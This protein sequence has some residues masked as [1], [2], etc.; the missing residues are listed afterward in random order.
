MMWCFEPVTVIL[1]EQVYFQELDHIG[2]PRIE[3][4]Y[5]HSISLLPRMGAAQESGSV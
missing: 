1:N 3:S 5:F 4:A 2:Q